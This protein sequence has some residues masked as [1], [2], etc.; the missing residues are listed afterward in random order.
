M[1]Y[2]NVQGLA[3]PNRVLAEALPTS[4]PTLQSQ[5]QGKVKETERIMVEVDGA[6]TLTLYIWSPVSGAWRTAGATTAKYEIAFAAA[7]MDFFVA[8]TGAKFYIKVAS[9]TVKAWTDGMPV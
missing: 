8:P 1:T 9:G 6:A 5:A 4:T 2:V 3:L 7:G